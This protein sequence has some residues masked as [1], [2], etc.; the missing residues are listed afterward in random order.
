MQVFAAQVS[1][2]RAARVVVVLSSYLAQTGDVLQLLAVVC[3]LA[4]VIDAVSRR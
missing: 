4:E 3:Q 2:E 1:V